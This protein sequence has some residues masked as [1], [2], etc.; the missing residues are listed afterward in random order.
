MKNHKSYISQGII[1]TVS[2][3]KRQNALKLNSV[4]TVNKI[5]GLGKLPTHK[6]NFSKKKKS[7]K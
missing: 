1:N 3:K 7:K 2:H 6:E 5:I 4:V